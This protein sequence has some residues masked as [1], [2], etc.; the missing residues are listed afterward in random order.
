MK[1]ISVSTL[2]KNIKKFFDE[3]TDS[4]QTI[5]VPRKD[6]EKAVV[7]ISIDEYNSW[8]ETEHLLESQANRTRLSES[9]NQAEK[10]D[11]ETSTLKLNN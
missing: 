4:N 11:L 2:R 1:A 7:I 3:V 6:D 8:K 5:V 9:M 10:D